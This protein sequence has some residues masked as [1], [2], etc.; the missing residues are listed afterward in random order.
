MKLTLIGLVMLAAACHDSTPI[1]EFAG[2]QGQES[3]D[4]GALGALLARH[5]DADGM[6]DY[7]TWKARDVKAL[8]D[9]LSQVRAAAPSKLGKVEAE[10]FWIN[11]YNAVT[12][13]AI[14][15]FMPLKSIRDKVSS[16]GGY[17]VW[18]D[19]KIAIEGR[20]LS[21]ND[22]EHRILRKMGDPRIHFAINCASRS[23]PRLLAE[24]YTG[25]RLEEQ[26]DS[27][28][29]HFFR[30]PGNYRLDRDAKRVRLSRI[31]EWFG[32]DFGPDERSRLTK[33]SAWLPEDDAKFLEQTTV[34]VEYLDY[35]WSLNAQRRNP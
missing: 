7:E 22:I 13:R 2:S 12:I 23:C 35:D 16:I 18:D 31:L 29:R 27:N 14:L 5:V 11:V 20:D 6:V 15:E 33:V 28:S 25:V 9:Y 1:A 10:A 17:N 19:Y 30:Q 24:A 34:T 8:D 4:H 26:L 3:F 21:L 32:E